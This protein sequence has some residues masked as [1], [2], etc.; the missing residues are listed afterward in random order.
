M[1]NKIREGH[2]PIFFLS[3]FSSIANLFL[4][5]VLTRILLP[6]EI[7]LYKIFFL[8]FAA[9]PFIFM[10]GG[11]LNSVY[12][13]VGK[14]A[15]QRNAYIQ[16]SFL[17]S[18]FL[19]LLIL[20]IGFPFV[21]TLSNFMQIPWQYVV[22]LLFSSFFAVPAAFYNEVN[23][24][25]GKTLKGSLYSVSFEVA[26]V[27]SFIAIAYLVKDLGNIFL[28]Y[29]VI[30]GT[31]FFVTIV[32]GM[33]ENFIRFN[34]DKEKLTEIF[35]YCFPISLAGLVTF[36]IDKMD[37]FVL[38]S[39]LA[40]DEFA[41]YSMGCLIIPPL[42]L[43]EMSVSKVLIPK[44][45]NSFNTDDGHALAHFRK[46]ISDVGFLIIPGVFGLFYFAEPITTLLYTDK[47]V[48]SA[49]YL[50]IFA[51]SYLFFLIPYDAVPRATGNTK[52]IFKITLAIAPFSLAGIILSSKY[53]DAKTVL[54]V[55]LA[56]KFIARVAGL[57]YSAKLG[58]WT[59]YKSIPWKK[60]IIFTSVSL[61]L[62]YLC[63][64]IQGQFDSEIKWFLTTAPIFAIL[65][66]GALYIPHKK[67]IFHD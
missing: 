17:L 6:S 27:I 22:V 2:W 9:I 45:S 62:T 24:A 44:L 11:P 31:K 59:V 7:G 41:F 13:W 39:Q 30:F 20:I 14:P 51:L 61:V 23:I 21:S 53:A 43:L 64:L 5:I 34:I 32:L 4:P 33:R 49:V 54:I 55:A 63:S 18:L 29:A 56:F 28:S 52:W 12:Y 36:F 57:M 47:F 15:N 50:K 40:K 66:L 37:Q 38:A 19:S 58:K 67:G 3:S 35:K 46:A 65:Y 8:H 60:L 26:K 42:Y 48:N 1:L 10:T 25:L 16:Q